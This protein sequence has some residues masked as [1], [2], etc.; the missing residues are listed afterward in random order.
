MGK[1]VK[2]RRG[3]TVKE[4]SS[5]SIKPGIKNGK[6]LPTDEIYLS[7]RSCWMRLDLHPQLASLFDS[8]RS[9]LEGLQMEKRDPPREEPPPPEAEMEAQKTPAI[10]EPPEQKELNALEFLWQ[11]RYPL[12]VTFWLFFVLGN[13]VIGFLLILLPRSPSS[14]FIW[15]VVIFAL[16]LLAIIY[17]VVTLVA[18]WRAAG[19]HGDSMFG[20]LAR[21]IVTLQFASLA[22]S[23]GTGRVFTNF[24]GGSGDS[25]QTQDDR[26]RMELGMYLLNCHMFWGKSGD[27]EADCTVQAVKE[28]TSWKPGGDI[29]ISGSGGRDDWAAT[30]SFKDS[31]L[32]YSMNS[33]GE[34][35]VVK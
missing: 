23:V 4:Y 28:D 32:V 10:L 25:I 21:I 8:S 24:G 16:T 7:N 6:L 1:K 22:F 13:V 33:A 35:K 34:L 15:K 31:E 18:T 19:D 26:A 20:K 5:D 2:L 27:S 17:Y 9:S 30:A 14:W 12:W 11:G 29:N 3:K